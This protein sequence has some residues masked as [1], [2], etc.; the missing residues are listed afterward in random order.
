[1]CVSSVKQWIAGVSDSLS[2]LSEYA[3]LIMWNASGACQ[4]INLTDITASGACQNI[5]LTDITASGAC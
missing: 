4:N 1:M 2:K 3:V 5:N